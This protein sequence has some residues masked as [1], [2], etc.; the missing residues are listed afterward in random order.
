LKV[1][2]IYPDVGTMLP[3]DYQHG[4]G[5]LLAVLKKA[6]HTPKL[7][8]VHD[9]L[10][11]E[12]LIAKIKSF[13]PGLVAVSTVSNQYQRSRKYAKWLK[14][15]FDV[16]IVI[17]GMHATLAPEE[18]ISENCFDMLC[19]GEGEG[20]I[21][22]LT[23]GLENGSDISAIQNLWLKKDSK[24]I[25]NELRPLVEDLDTLPFVDR[26]TFHFEK[27]L[28]AQGG[29]C[30]MLSGRGCPF[31]CTYCANEGIRALYKGKGRFV[32]MRSVEHVLSEMREILENY[33][34][35]K[36]E[37]NDDI[38]TLKKKWM[39]KFCEL[40]GAEFDIPFDV[41]VRVETVDRQA[42]QIL[43]DAGC[44]LIR[45]GVESGSERVR[46]QLMKR[47]MT[48][49]QIEN[50]FEDA[51]A[52]GLKTWSFN[53]VGLPGETREDAEETIRL[54]EKLCPDHMQVSV[55]NPYPG[56]R[57][58]EKCIEE[59]ILSGRRVDGYFLPDSVL[60]QPDFPAQEINAAHQRLVRLRDQCTTKKRILR[61]LDGVPPYFDFVEK[62]NEAKIETPEPQFVG[63]DYFW[64]GEDARRVLRAHPPANILYKVKVPKAAVLKFSIAMHPQV[65]DRGVGGGVIF[66]IFAGRFKKR[67]KQIF[68]TTLNPKDIEN[69][70][71]WHDFKIDLKNFAG[72]NI[73]M[74]FMTRTVEIENQEHN[75]VGFGYPM[76]LEVS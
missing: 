3:P 44:D 19:I 63:E 32:R 50:T 34:V 12:D 13:D 28:L 53:M 15:K 71:G 68:E 74:E 6:G 69:D 23:D 39:E 20:A 10:S 47:N 8:Y 1:L 45:I 24:I 70:R 65:L 30:S 22:E 37:F 38:F 58:Y 56:T 31:G 76:I 40:Y 35:T 43:K 46:K 73:Y 16:P 7:I 51:E 14:E 54:N 9:E 49:A 75:T 62:I 36:W 55:F 67:M 21:V 48:N 18:V 4:V 42:L 57:L 17:G 5:T 72:K 66:S 29:K 27:I 61:E 25:K 64:I 52:V 59:G 60:V 11:R 26:E 2:F 41:N 33:K